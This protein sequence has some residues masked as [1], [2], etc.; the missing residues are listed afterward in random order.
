MRPF[1]GRAP[2][3]LSMATNFCYVIE[4]V[5]AGMACPGLHGSLREDLEF[6]KSQGIG[7]VVTLTE[8]SLE[9]NEVE[10]LGF[11][12]LHLPVEDFA[13]PALEQVEAFLAFLRQAEA[14]GVPV[15]VHCAAGRGRTGTML[16]CAL[17]QRGVTA[18]EAI[19]RLRELRPHSV[20]TLEQ[21]EMVRTLERRLK[22]QG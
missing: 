8:Y 12:Y 4:G 7:A 9:R 2:R 15:T 3:V 11:R 10:R 18:E 13:P 22:A 20:E 5:L 21:E 1:E 14:D 19:G 17:V 16:A 6:L